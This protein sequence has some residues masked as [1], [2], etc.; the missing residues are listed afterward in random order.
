MGG[1]V[2]DN[3]VVRRIVLLRDKCSVKMKWLSIEP[4]IG[5][6]RRSTLLFRVKAANSAR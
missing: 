6:S 5:R 1:S 3:N 4:L 2:E